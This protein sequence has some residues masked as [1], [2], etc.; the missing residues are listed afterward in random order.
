[1]TG[2]CGANTIVD[3]T[4]TDCPPPEAF[5]EICDGIDN[6]SDGE[7][8]E[9]DPSLGASCTSALP[10]PC[11]PGALICESGALVCRPLVAAA[12]E[13]CG[14]AVDES[15]DGEPSCAGAHRF[16]KCGPMVG[17]IAVDAKDNVYAAG[18]LYSKLTMIVDGQPLGAPG[19]QDIVVARIDPSGKTDQRARVGDIGVE[20]YASG[21]AVDTDGYITVAGSL[22]PD[23]E[24]NGEH[25]A[26]V[27]RLD[28]AGHAVFYFRLG[29]AGPQYG[30]DVAVDAA[31][32]V[33]MVGSGTG[34]L[35]LGQGS[36]WGKEQNACFIVK[37]D[38]AG[39]PAFSRAFGAGDDGYVV[40]GNVLAMPDGSILMTGSFHGALDLG[41]GVVTGSGDGGMFVLKLDAAGKTI[42]SK[43]IAGPSLQV[44]GPSAAM[45][46]AGNLLLAWSFSGSMTIG[47]DTFFAE[48]PWD[49]LVVK[50][51]PGGDPLWSRYFAT[52]EYEGVGDL[53]VDAAGNVV[54]VGTYS[55]PIDFGGG[56]LEGTTGVYD[57]SLFIVKLDEN[58][59]HV[60]SKGYGGASGLQEK[61]YAVAAKSTGG[62]VIGG[63]IPTALDWG[64]ALHD[65]CKDPGAHTFLVELS[66]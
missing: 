60:W 43:V 55:S 32:N 46:V 37:Y 2:G 47:G 63:S 18:Y 13:R 53:S 56:P 19:L 34:T 27:T 58:G 8:D 30:G 11:A 4:S 57:E 15:C 54:L 50:L 40:P 49:V 48:K 26:F 42:W 51:D 12:A 16:T 59:N 33:I 62:I 35:D 9:A 17:K 66:P 5:T 1:M 20:E 21:I 41:T 39:R 65:G 61:G 6:D 44:I 24:V 64:G 31:G 14:T 52:P 45:D 25:D 7:I 38:P 29:G 36:I 3:S 28:P 10:G 23:F 22:Y